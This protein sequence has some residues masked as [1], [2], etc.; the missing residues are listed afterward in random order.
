MIKLMMILLL[1]LLSGCACIP[2]TKYIKEKPYTF[3]KIKQP[4]ERTIRIYNDDKLLYNA[5][6]K[7]FRDIIDFYNSQIN[8]YIE[9]KGE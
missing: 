3:Q 7:K 8:D 6:I 5:Y 1:L 9:A 4:K 2:N